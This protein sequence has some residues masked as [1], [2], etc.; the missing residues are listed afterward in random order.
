MIETEKL[1]AFMT[2]CSENIIHETNLGDNHNCFS[3]DFVN[4][5]KEALNDIAREFDL[6][7]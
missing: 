4:G 2:V 7:W 5:Y 6:D 3:T 1:L